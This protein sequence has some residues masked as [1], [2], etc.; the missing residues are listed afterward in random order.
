MAEWG[1]FLLRRFWWPAEELGIDIELAS[2]ADGKN[3]VFHGESAL[4]IE[5]RR[6]FSFR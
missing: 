4:V 3:F 5:L 1:R 2:F 6:R